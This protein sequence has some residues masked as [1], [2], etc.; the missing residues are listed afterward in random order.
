MEY[1]YS[2]IK[3]DDLKKF[4]NIIF[5][6]VAEGLSGKEKQQKL[7]NFINEHAQSIRTHYCENICGEYY[8]CKV[9]QSFKDKESKVD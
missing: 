2:C 6:N 9:Y 1:L 4:E 3:L 5:S 7:T 8:R